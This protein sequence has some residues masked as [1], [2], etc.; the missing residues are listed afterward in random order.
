M[1]V[2]EDARSNTESY[3]CNTELSEFNKMSEHSDFY[4]TLER[5]KTSLSESDN[6]LKI[7]FLHSYKTWQL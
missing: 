4:H 7:L 2:P 3:I 5:R 1:L 6:N